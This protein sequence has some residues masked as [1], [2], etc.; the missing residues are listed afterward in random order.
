MA[1]N[2]GL[3]GCLMLELDE[4]WKRKELLWKQ[5]FRFEWLTSSDLNSRFFHA[6]SVIRRCKN[7]I[8]RLKSDQ[9]G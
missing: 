5:K 8:E 1:E 4:L 2:L 3:E 6:S 9:A 7:R